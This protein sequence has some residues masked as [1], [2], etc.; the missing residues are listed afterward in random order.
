MKHFRTCGVSNALDEA[1]FEVNDISSSKEDK[2]LVFFRMKS[3]LVM[4]MI[5]LFPNFLIVLTVVWLFKCFQL[6][7]CSLRL[8]S[9]IYA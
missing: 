5:K 8:L 9:S 1:L 6:M 3:F 4:K 2:D 7:H